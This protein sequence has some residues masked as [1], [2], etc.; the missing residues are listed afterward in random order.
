[1]KLLDFLPK[2]KV[3]NLFSVFSFS[4]DNYGKMAHKVTRILVIKTSIVTCMVLLT[5]LQIIILIIMKL[6]SEKKLLAVFCVDKLFTFLKIRC[7]KMSK[8]N[9]LCRVTI[10]I[11]RMG[12]FCPQGLKIFH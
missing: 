2:Y 10:I 11:Y 4:S 3:T 12:P 5:F 6:A 8:H 9:Y 7:K 1:M